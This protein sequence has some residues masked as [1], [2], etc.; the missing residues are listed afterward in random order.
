MLSYCR[1]TQRVWFT[2]MN[3]GI[4]DRQ[5]ALPMVFRLAP[6]K[7]STSRRLASLCPSANRTLLIAAEL[8]ETW[9]V[10]ED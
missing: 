3:E 9:D 10:R 6:S 5:Y 1:Q 7:A 8:M 2:R 4:H